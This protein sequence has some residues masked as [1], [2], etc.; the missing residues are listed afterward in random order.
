[1]STL[2]RKTA[3]NNANVRDVQ[4]L[5]TEVV[6][7]EADIVT[8]EAA[9]VTLQPGTSVG[10]AAVDAATTQALV[11]ELRVIMIATGAAS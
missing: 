9:I 10:V 7:A 2:V 11:N 1:M 8:A 6:T 5:A 4:D 3:S